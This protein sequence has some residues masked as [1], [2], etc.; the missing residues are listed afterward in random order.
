[1]VEDILRDLGLYWRRGTAKLVEVAVEPLVNFGVELVV[2]VA[3]LLRG[4]VLLTRLGLRCSA[5]LVRTADIDGV[6]ASQ[7]AVASVHVAREDTADDVAQMRHIV[8]VREG[9]GDQNISLALFWKHDPSLSA[10]DFGVGGADCCLR[11]GYTA[12]GGGLGESIQVNKAKFSADGFQ[13]SLHFLIE[14]F[15]G[16]LKVRESESREISRAL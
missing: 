4:H 2:F 8:D 1:V 11:F 3:D 15:A 10:S 13:R 9:A 12:S 14:E 7:T 16:R 6:V 5:I